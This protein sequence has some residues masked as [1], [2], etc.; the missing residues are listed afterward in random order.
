MT[1]LTDRPRQH[2]ADIDRIRARRRRE[3]A[4]GIFALFLMTGIVIGIPVA[5]AL[6]FRWPLP[7]SMP[8]SDFLTAPLSFDVVLNAIACLVWLAWVHLVVCLFVEWRSG[9]RGVGLTPRIP[10]AGA[11]QDLARRL[12]GAVLLLST[13]TGAASVTVASATSAPVQRPSV[14]VVQDQGTPPAL[15]VEQD[16]SKAQAAAAAQ[17]GTR[18]H[19]QLVCT[20]MPPQGRYHD[21]LWDIAERHLG[22]GLRYKEIFALNKGRVFPDGRKLTEASLIHPGWKLIMPADAVGLPAATPAPPTPPVNPVNPSGSTAAGPSQ[23]APGQVNDSSA[24]GGGSS[25]APGLSARGGGGPQAAPP[26]SAPRQAAPP[27]AAVPP[28]TSPPHAVPPGAD[29]PPQAALPPA[30]P[31]QAGPPHTAVPP[32]ASPPHAV[33]SGAAVP[34]QVAPPPAV[35]PQV[36][37]PKAAEAQPATPKP[38]KAAQNAAVIS[39]IGATQGSLPV[40]AIALWGLFGVELLAFGVIEAVIA[41]RRRQ[42]QRREPGEALPRPN[43]GAAALEVALRSQ[44]DGESAQFLDRAL[45]A[46]VV[47]GG[48]LPEAYAARLTSH[49][50]E[51]LLSSARNDAPFP[52]VA[53]DD[54]R[55]WALAREAALPS[56]EYARAPM[57]GLVSVGTD[58]DAR[59][60]V[61]LEAA[62]GVICLDGPEPKCRAL[63]A[64]AAAELATNVWSDHVRLTLVG[65]GEELVALAPDRV[66]WVDQVTDVLPELESRAASNASVPPDFDG[67]SVL[68][69]RVRPATGHDGSPDYLLLAQPPDDA[70]LRRLT[71][72]AAGQRNGVGVMVVGRV[73]GARWTFQVDAQGD[74]DTGPLGLRLRAAQLAEPA[75]SALAELLGTA[76]V[77]EF[78]G[79]SGRPDIDL[80][81]PDVPVDRHL[82]ALG[83]PQ[84]LAPEFPEDLAVDVPPIRLVRL[85]GPPDVFSGPA[86]DPPTPLLVEMIAYLAVNRDGVSPEALTAAIWPR[87]SRASEREGAMTQLGEWL[88]VDEAGKPRLILDDEGWLR[89][90]SEVRLDW[91]QFAALVTRGQQ[92]DLRRALELVRGP[93]AD[94]APAGRYAW[95]GETAL[96]YDAPALIADTAHQ[97]AAA[98]LGRGDPAGAANAA[99]LGLRVDEGNEVL[100]R[101]LVRSEQSVGGIEAA[102]AVARDMVAT[103][104]RIGGLDLVTAETSAVIRALL[105]PAAVQAQDA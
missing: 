11:S 50:L 43:A 55:V 47:E 88:G 34:P 48:T 3:V 25:V 54:G 1:Q 45:R 12:V 53:E 39:A 16:Q 99:R 78:D 103:L 36:S 28:H 32:H 31:P 60:L 96:P 105:Q 82:R 66:R 74:L 101:D 71:V 51:L 10:F 72:L 104:Q 29:V 100:W 6:L 70:T 2:P 23:A 27:H 59:V 33:P 17:S 84:R 76:T 75:Y 19:G 18:G 67:D 22:D 80:L 65:F 13:A 98:Y 92:A 46:A 97:L 81:N 42:G 94:G 4:A 5:L 8:T 85:L 24:V 7:T 49:R 58:G 38:A 91:H 44:A 37:P 30:A 35:P 15:E 69:G 63:L 57:P 73:A 90:S 20:V 56:T 62:D 9:R 52:F 14:A 93:I 40:E 95:L 61:D 68:T 79:G 87:G 41:K 64:A 102:R 86:D 89:L 83:T 21:N 77:G 26:Q